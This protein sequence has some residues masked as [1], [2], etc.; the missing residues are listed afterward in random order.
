MASY[1]RAK[2]AQADVP[3]SRDLIYQPSLIELK[4]FIDPQVHTRRIILDQKSEGACTGFALAAAINMMNQHAGRDIQ[5]SARMLYEMAK[6]NDEWP[7]EEY[8]G[9]SLRG[10]I[11]GWRNMGVCE[12]DYWPYRVGNKKGS[13]TIDAAK[14]AR[15]HTLGSYYRLRPIVSDFHSALNETGVI[16]ASAK[17]HRGWEKPQNGIIER[18]D[19]REGGHAFIIVGYNDEGFWIQNSWGKGWGDNGVALWTYEDWIENVMDA[20]VLRPSLPTPQIFGKKA[21]AS[22]LA[23]DVAEKTEKSATPRSEIAGHFIHVDDGVYKTSGRYWSSPEDIEQTA[24]LVAHSEKYEH[25]LIYAHGGLNSPKASAHRIAAMKDTYKAN[26]IYPFHIM[27]DTGI[28]E[29]LKDLLLRKEDNAVERTGGFSDW[30]DRF[31]E[32]LVRRPGTLLWNEMKQDAEDAFAP[33]G[34]GTDALKRFIKHIRQNG[35]KVKFHLVGHSTG[36]IVIAHLL[37]TLRRTSVNFSSCSLL[38]PACSIDLY[39]AAYLPV[40]ED[41]TKLKIDDLAVYNLKDQLEQDDAVAKVYRKSLLYLVSNAFEGVKERPLLGMEKFEDL[42][43]MAGSMPRFIYSNGVEGQRTRSTTHGGFDND[44]YTMN[45]V[46]K[47]VLGRK[48]DQPFTR[49]ILDY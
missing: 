30:T 5:V 26:G 27:Y 1:K 10:A 32:G 43:Q 12:D 25:I 7:G 28:V 9:S 33:Q 22:L 15:Q 8:D 37:Q 21:G 4:K 41:K 20:W 48:P 19:K 47:R 14:N 3:D 31:V 39:H 35:R 49:E 17:V 45:H 23:V 24:E 42:A 46:L 16:A 40:L 13:L 11:R 18:H 6:R 29:E 38:A 36:A 2:N 44:P 34:A